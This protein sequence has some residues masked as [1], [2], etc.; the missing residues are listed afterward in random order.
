MCGLPL[1]PQG[2]TGGVPVEQPRPQAG[3]PG[4][5]FPP[6]LP[7]PPPP[8]SQQQVGYP[9]SEAPRTAQGHSVLAA[10]RVGSP[11]KWQFWVGIALLAFVLTCCPCTLAVLIYGSDALADPGGFISSI[12][13]VGACLFLVAF[14]LGIILLRVGRPRRLQ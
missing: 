4:S 10:L 7:P 3:L 14:V 5:S 9:P 1:I 12:L 11:A 2:G 6:P 8:S 13:G